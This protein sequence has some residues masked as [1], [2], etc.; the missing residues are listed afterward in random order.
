MEISNL[1]LMSDDN[2]LYVV[3]YYSMTGHFYKETKIL[4]YEK[5]NLWKLIKRFVKHAAK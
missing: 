3:E 2:E 4:S 5:E 1:F